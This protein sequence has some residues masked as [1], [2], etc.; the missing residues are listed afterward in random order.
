M[1]ETMENTSLYTR[2]AKVRMVIL[3][4]DGV[5]TDGGIYIA[6][7]GELYKPFNVRDG[8]GIRLWEKAGGRTAI[9]TGRSSEI[10]AFRAKELEIQDVYMGSLDKRA[11]YDELKE[12]CQLQ[13]AEI[14]YIGDDLI[15]MPI[16]VQTGF[17]VAVG[18]AVDEV[19]AI[20]AL[21][22]KSTGGH[23]AV[24]ET[25]ELILRA[26]GKWNSIVESFQRPAGRISGLGQ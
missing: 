1:Q 16:M 4:V 26:Q 7:S 22:T 13:D 15:D 20:A 24:R 8:L 2:A 10:M 3:D 17:P 18:D 19:K 5:L 6:A 11:A 21:V 12:K 14:A 9:I 25:L 23:G